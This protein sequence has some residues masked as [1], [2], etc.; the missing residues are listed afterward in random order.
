MEF[1]MH[2]GDFPDMPSEEFGSSEEFEKMMDSLR[3]RQRMNEHGEEVCQ[4]CGEGSIEWKFSVTHESV[5]ENGVILSSQTTEEV[6]I[7]DQCKAMLETISD[8]EDI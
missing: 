1:R 4:F 5:D 8:D 6:G 3:I 2:D 7:C